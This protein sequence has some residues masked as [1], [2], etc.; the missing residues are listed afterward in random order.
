MRSHTR[1]GRTNGPVGRLIGLGMIGLCLWIGLPKGAAAQADLFIPR[2]DQPASTAKAGAPPRLIRFMTTDDFAPLNF[3]GRGG[4]TS[5]FNVAL[6]RA[7][8]ESL[9]TSCSMQVVPWQQLE[10]RL[11]AGRGDVAIAGHRVEGRTGELIETAPYL[12]NPARFVVLSD[13]LNAAV[14]TVGVLAGS[15]H[16]LYLE[17]FEPELERRSY[18]SREALWSALE[19][20]E[21]DAIFLD[22]L[23]ASLR[24]TSAAGD[25]CALKPGAYT[26]T[27]YFGEGL[28][29]L[30]RSDDASL[31]QAIETALSQ[32]IE[33][34]T[35]AELYLRYFPFGLY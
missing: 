6:A 15:A 1:T 18:D 16:A 26:E 25:C 22:A 21:V 3:R 20:S 34:G 7:I 24:L 35:F 27:R 23:S 12:A 13:N 14:E 30:V 28:A 31:A 9:D 8:C 32:V 11:L 33:A 29:M 17:A 5:G 2:Y 19:A 10:T 4:E